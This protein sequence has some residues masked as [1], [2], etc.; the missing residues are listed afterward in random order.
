MGNPLGGGVLLTF[1][2]SSIVRVGFRVEFLFRCRFC[3]FLLIFFSRKFQLNWHSICSYE[4]KSRAF[5]LC[6]NHRLD[7]EQKPCKCVISLNIVLC[8]KTFRFESKCVSQA[9]QKLCKFKIK[10][11]QTLLLLYIIYKQTLWK[12]RCNWI[13]FSAMSCHTVPC[14]LCMCSMCYVCENVQ[15][16]RSNKTELQQ[17]ISTFSS[18]GLLFLASVYETAKIRGCMCIL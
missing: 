7:H 16:C 9:L 1:P 11:S 15:I 2:L 6:E 10:K 17:A 12:V 3:L 8:E 14:S 13:E 5:F 18:N 4:I